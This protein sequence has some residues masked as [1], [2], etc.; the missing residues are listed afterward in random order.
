MEP[1]DKAALGYRIINWVGII[2]QLARNQGNRAIADLNLPW[3]QFVMLN[4]FR[5]RPS[6]GKTVTE[7][8][9]AMQQQQPGV[10]KTLK[11]MVDGGLLRIES[12]KKDGRVKRHFLT[13]RGLAIHA[14]AVTRLAPGIEDMF[15]DWDIE[16][17]ADLFRDLD[18]LKRWLDENR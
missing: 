13:E 15:A 9:R 5:H 12:D 2:E 16:A 4:H 17:M 10:T 11:A 7:V 6:D 1:S 18:V 3:P 14:E 8:A